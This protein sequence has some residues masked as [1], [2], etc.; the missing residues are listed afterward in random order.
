MLKSLSKFTVFIIIGL[1]VLLIVSVL[2]SH[3]DGPSEQ[4]E[5]DLFS[6][7]I[8]GAMSDEEKDRQREL[9]AKMTPEQLAEVHRIYAER[10]VK[11]L[12]CRRKK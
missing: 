1:I 7:Q 6:Q 9:E 8:E 2:W 3:D 10:L 12:E 4:E 5:L 11:L